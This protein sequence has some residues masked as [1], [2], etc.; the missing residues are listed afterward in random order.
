M[1]VHRILG[2]AMLQKKV[3]WLQ[4]TSP[5]INAKDYSKKSPGSAEAFR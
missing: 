3:R 4:M 2:A 5:E 1:R